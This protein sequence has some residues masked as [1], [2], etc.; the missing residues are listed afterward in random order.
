M[1]VE[2]PN[3]LDKVNSMEK[4]LDELEK[5]LSDIEERLRILPA[6]PGPHHPP[7][8]FRPGPG[9]RPDPFRM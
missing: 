7:D 3:L 5:R 2:N 4:R 8:P 6:P 9:P 1:S